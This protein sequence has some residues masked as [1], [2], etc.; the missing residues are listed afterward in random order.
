MTESWNADWL[1]NLPNIT[2]S[3][4]AGS[5]HRC[6]ASFLLTKSTSEPMFLFHKPQVTYASPTPS[7]PHICLLFPTWPST[8]HVH[9]ISTHTTPIRH[10]AP[11][12]G[13]RG[14][15]AELSTHQANHSMRWATSPAPQ[16]MCE[17]FPHGLLPIRIPFASKGLISHTYW[18]EY[19]QQYT[20]HVQHNTKIF[21]I[22]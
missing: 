14:S 17:A 1:S 5:P 20:L 3:G 12:F 9:H 13:T 16:C 6:C 19:Y 11:F 15:K 2:L 22:M 21:L 18:S 8:P 7:S 4:M 10:S